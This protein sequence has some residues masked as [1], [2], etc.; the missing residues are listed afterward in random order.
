MMRMR[1]WKTITVLTNKL[2]AK[3]NLNKIEVKKR[4]KESKLNYDEGKCEDR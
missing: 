4:Q 2:M 1:K 3:I